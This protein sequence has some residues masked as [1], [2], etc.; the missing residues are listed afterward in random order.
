MKAIN[1]YYA[2]PQAILDALDAGECSGKPELLEAAVAG[3]AL[4]MVRSRRPLAG[5]TASGILI[6]MVEGIA[7]ARAEVQAQR[8]TLGQRD[9]YINGLELTARKFLESQ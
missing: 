3:L 4:N 8:W 9:A 1:L 7:H 5:R 2:T 6:M